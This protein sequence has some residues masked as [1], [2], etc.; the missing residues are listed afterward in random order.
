MHSVPGLNPQTRIPL[1]IQLKHILRQK[2]ENKVYQVGDMIPN[3]TELQRQYGVSRAT[4]R[5]AIEEL[6][7]EGILVKKQGKGTFIQ[8]PKVTQ[9][10]NF[11]SSFGETMAAKGLQTKVTDVEVYLTDLTEQAAKRLGMQE[12]ATVTYVKRLYV[13]EDEPIALIIN[14][15]VPQFE[16][17]LTK[18]I[19]EK[20][21]LYHILEHIYGFTLDTA[22]ETVEAC[23]ANRY[24][25]NRLAVSIGAPLLRVTRVTYAPNGSP[26]E[27]V[28]VTSRADR[29]SYSVRLKG[30]ERKGLVGLPGQAY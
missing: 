20:Y 10:L 4:V 15:L 12:G 24:E 27:L 9:H 6:T 3:E 11:I 14:Y 26:I 7:F 2:I 25:A 5:K 30:R 23:C 18:E 28:I 21:S 19:L 16:P 1:Y 17:T 29:Y 13:A 22:E 8:K